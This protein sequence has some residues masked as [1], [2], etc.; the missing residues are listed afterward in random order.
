MRVILAA[1]LAVGLASATPEVRASRSH[2]VLDLQPSFREQSVALES[3]GQI[4][5]I[6]LNP[7]VNEWFL[8]EVEQEGGRQLFHLENAF[9]WEQVIV[10]SDTL[11]PVLQLQA[12]GDSLP[13]SLLAEISRR[14]AELGFDAKRAYVSL[15]DG[16]LYLRKPV[17]GGRTRRE[18][19][20]DLLRDRVRHGER[21]TSLVKESLYRDRYLKTSGREHRSSAEDE[22]DA[23]DSLSYPPAPIDVRD[24]ARSLTLMATSLDLPITTRQR[25]RMRAGRW[26]R[27]DGQ[28][29]AF[30]AAITPDLVVDSFSAAQKHLLSPIDRVEASA[31]VY[32]VAFDL[33]NL[34][35]G[36]EV[37][38]E[39][40]RVGW[41]DRVPESVRRLPAEG[42][43][44]IDTVAPLVRTGKLNPRDGGRVA[45]TFAGGFKR[46]HGAFKWGELSLVNK[47]SHYGFAEHGTVLSRLQPALATLVVYTDHRVDLKTWT[48]DDVDQ[49]SR[50]VH[51]RQNGV[52]LLET[53]P[54]GE[55][56]PGG[57][58]SDWG[59]GNWSGSETRQLRTLRAGVCIQEG[60]GRQFLLY[61][62]FSSATPSAMARV[63][64]A[65]GCRYAMHLDMNA[66]EH[67]YLAVYE[68]GPDGFVVNRLVDEMREVDP[69]VDGQEVPRFVA[70]PSSR[71]FFYLLRRD[72]GDDR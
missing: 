69:P 12:A 68:V 63:F 32:L 13:C 42:P 33:D 58:V 53:G 16:R 48:P 60:S 22:V 50:I 3:G 25:G 21:L 67:T 57:L 27:V 20:A 47:G 51:A 66:P 29:H 41:S 72:G 28:P 56:V 36:F 46:S 62:Y 45:A 71:D 9:P 49:L 15:C 31:L 55:V 1:A 8:L 30:V 19:A 34:E 65:C 35:L 39:H 54:T 2:S 40:P 64:G 23:A 14:P 44:G 43:D 61:G 70:Y 37:G 26:Y 18:W 5:L 59:K 7:S 4:S 11:S 10:L 24:E 6:E 38:T 17:A 52:P